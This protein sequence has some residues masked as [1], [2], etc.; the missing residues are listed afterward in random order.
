MESRTGTVGQVGD[1]HNSLCCHQS[2]GTDT[3]LGPPQAEDDQYS[4]TK[5]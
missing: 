2:R 4:V 5:G 1:S 3:P